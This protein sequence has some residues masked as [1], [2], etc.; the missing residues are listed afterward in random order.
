MINTR[1]QVRSREIMG[2]ARVSLL[3]GGDEGGKGPGIGADIRQTARALEF[4]GS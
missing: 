1:H 4:M 2:D 3:E